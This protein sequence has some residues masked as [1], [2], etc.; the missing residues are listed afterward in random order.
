MEMKRLRVR[1]TFTEDVLGTCPNNTELHTDYVASKA[2]DAARME[3][4]IEA[5]GASEY[6]EKGMTVFP[7]SQ[8]GE[9]MLYD[10]QIK[11]FF[12]DSAKALKR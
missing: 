6:A 7:R 3:E 1:I 4:E 9:P 12:K 5:M 8:G 11:G 2:P 10:Y